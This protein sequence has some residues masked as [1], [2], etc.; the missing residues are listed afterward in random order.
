MDIKKKMKIKLGQNFLIDPRTAEREIRYAEVN[1]EDTVL[2]IGPGNGIITQKLAEKAKQ[3]IAIEIDKNLILELKPKLPENVELIQGDAVKIDFNKLKKFNKI[4]SNLPYQ[5]SSPIIFKILENEFKVAILILQKEFAERL[6]AEPNTK[7]YSRL[8]VNAYY[9]YKTKILE[10]IPR[11]VFKPVPRVDSC[12]VELKPRNRP[13]F[14]LNDEKIFFELTK[15]LF[16]NRRKKIKNTLKDYK[17]AL[18]K[19]PYVDMR[20]E[21]LTPEQIGEISN[22]ITK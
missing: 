20:V 13:P 17:I 6:T 1:K 5:I 22:I 19:I 8:T 7:K 2:E 11:S 16:N 10:Y 12:I 9:K 14:I 18:D 4:V 3:V 21:Q 15:R